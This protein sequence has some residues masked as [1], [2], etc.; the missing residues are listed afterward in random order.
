VFSSPPATP[1]A[2]AASSVK[3][4]AKTESRRNNA[5]SL[6]EQVVAPIHGRLQGP[7]TGHDDPATACEK[8]KPVVE[9]RGDL[10][11]SEHPGTRRRELD[12]ERYTV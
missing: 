4:P 11:G 5:R 2:S 7:L 12:G 9:A 10:G 1:I 8:E 3:P 6:G